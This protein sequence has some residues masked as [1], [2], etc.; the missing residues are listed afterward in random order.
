MSKIIL[1]DDL[2]EKLIEEI[3]KFSDDIKRKIEREVI[4]SSDNI[5]KD[6]KSTAPRSDRSKPFA[7]SFVKSEQGEGV[8]KSITIHSK[9]KWRIIHF[10]EFGFVHRTGKFI[11]PR[12]FLRPIVDKELPKLLEGVK[13]IIRGEK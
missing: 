1:I 5:I 11:A 8:N 7:D 3:N 13:A 9:T 4:T 12:P 10:I 2:P 6:I